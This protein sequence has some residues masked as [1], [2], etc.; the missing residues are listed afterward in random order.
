MTTRNYDLMKWIF[1]AMMIA[2]IDQITKY[3]ATTHLVYGDPKALMPSINF[4]LFH[5]TGA[6]FSFLADQGGWQR[7]F[8]A[9]LT[10]MISVGLIVWLKFLSYKEIATR[11]AICLILGGAIGNLIDRLAWGYVIDFIQLYYSNWYWPIFNIADASIT[12]GAVLMIFAGSSFEK[13]V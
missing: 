9:T 3:L 7:W 8:F 4:T 10:I 11:I 5:N 13:G 2:V 6:A 1:F 12:I